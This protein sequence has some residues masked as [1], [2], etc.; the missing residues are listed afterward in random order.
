MGNCNSTPEA[1]AGATR[2]GGAKQQ[3]QQ[4]TA[5]AGAQKVEHQPQL[6]RQESAGVAKNAPAVTKAVQEP[7][8]EKPQDAKVEEKAAAPLPPPQMDQEAA[9]AGPVERKPEKTVEVQAP[10]VEEA[11]PAAEPE[12]E[13]EPEALPEAE[14]VVEAEADPEPEPQEPSDDMPPSDDEPDAAVDATAVGLFNPRNEATHRPAP[15][16]ETPPPV[17]PTDPPTAEAEEDSVLPPAADE[18]PAA[19]RAL[20][21]S[22][23]GILSKA[24]AP[25]P[26]P[27]RKKRVVR[28]LDLEAVKEC[29]STDTAKYSVGERLG[30]G[31]YGLVVRGTNVKTG[32]EVAV[33][34]ISKD[35]LKKEGPAGEKRLFREVAIMGSLNHP[36][37]VNMTELMHYEAKN[38]M[39]IIV[40]LVEGCELMNCVDREVRLHEDTARSYFQQIVVGMNYVHSQGVV[41]RDLKPENILVT[42]DGLCKITDFGLSNVQNT[43]TMGHV[44]SNL[45]VQTCCGTPYYVAP[46]VVTKKEGYSGFT[47]DVW[48]LGIILYVMLVGELPFTAKDLRSLLHK[49]SKGEYKIPAAA[50]LSNEAKDLLSRI[51]VPKVK[52]RITL[53]EIAEHP[54][55]TKGGFDESLMRVDDKQL[56]KRAVEHLTSVMDE[57]GQV[58]EAS[59]EADAAR[60]RTLALGRGGQNN[61]AI[62]AE[63]TKNMGN[64]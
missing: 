35:L 26:A 50:K 39:W 3:Q 52:N 61:R 5:S 13:P 47:S 8:A 32:E 42:N 59:K 20:A 28:T 40:E 51:L 1:G 62:F 29:I 34:R 55:F 43:D 48:S 24:S 36:N 4:Q 23:P 63:M 15:L 46:E 33:K 64:K 49:I 6:K 17:Q 25:A 21:M 45:N 60:S 16:P 11:P 18:E 10:V 56:D 37:L 12:P 14:P 7:A 38:E 31:A 58:K 2:Q 9:P 22:A 30:K 57:W 27:V 19:A 44:P 54:W 53:K 41:H